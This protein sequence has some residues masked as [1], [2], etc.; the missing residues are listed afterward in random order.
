[1][2]PADLE[3]QTLRRLLAELL[4]SDP[5]FDAFCLDHFPD[6]HRRFASGM[7]RTQKENL[8]LVHAPSQAQIVEAFDRD[9]DGCDRSVER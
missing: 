7:E 4:R 2:G 6:V 1:M 9:V 5:D 3:P 8:L